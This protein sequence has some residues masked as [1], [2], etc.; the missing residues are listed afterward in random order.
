M[1]FLGT[2]DHPAENFLDNF[3]QQHGG[4]LNANTEE[5]ATNYFFDVQHTA[6]L[7]TLPRFAS[8]FVCPLLT[9]SAVGREINQIESEFE[10]NVQND[11]WRL[12]QLFAH[13]SGEP[14]DFNRFSTGFLQFFIFFIN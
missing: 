12:R 11:S 7:K 8:L 1:L 4:T 9:E 5:T 14:S 2:K 13:L 6:L 3:L 10:M